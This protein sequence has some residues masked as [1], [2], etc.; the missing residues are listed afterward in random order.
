MKRAKI[1]FVFTLLF[2]CMAVTWVL[3]GAKNLSE[4]PA[5]T[6]NGVIDLAG[7]DLVN[8]IALLPLDW[9]YYPGHLYD[10]EQIARGEAGAPRV[11]IPE[12]E[13]AHQ[14]G[15]YR[16]VLQVAPG[17][18]YALAAWSIDYAT[19]IYIDGQE[20]LSIGIVSDSPDSFVPRTQSYVLPIFAQADT[21]EI[22][23]QYAN[24][25]H[26]EG[27]V[28]RELR[29]S[30]YEN[31][32]QYHRQSTIPAYLTSGSLLL[33]AVFYTLQFLL[34]RHA[35]VITFALCCLALALRSQTFLLSVLPIDYNWYFAYKFSFVGSVTMAVSCTLLLGFLYPGRVSR[36][37]VILYLCIA[38]AFVLAAVISPVRVV[39]RL[40]T[41]ATAVFAVVTVYLIIQ[42]IRLFFSK[43]PQDK[44]AAAGILAL[45]V[46]L[47]LDVTLMRVLPGITRNGIA[48]LGML[49]FV[50]CYML[51]LGIRAEE[52]AVHLRQERQRTENLAQLN[53]MKTEFL[54]NVTHELKTPLT[55]MS[56]SA[57]DTLAILPEGIP[58]R[59]GIIYNQEHIITEAERLDRIVIQLLDTAAIEAG[60]VTITREPISLTSLLQYMADTYFPRLGDNGNR[61][62]TDFAD[63]LPD[64]PADR[65]RIE[66]VVLN[67]LTNADRHTQNGLIT[68]TLKKDRSGQRVTVGDTG[69]GM[70]SDLQT[71]VFESYVSRTGGRSGMGLYICHKIIAAH[72]G[73][74]WIES[75]T[76]AGTAVSF[77]LPAH[78]ERD[79]A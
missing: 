68:L 52:N 45:F 6:E 54:Q 60:R 35:E 69:E 23:I 42:A 65:E 43:M 73:K 9:D 33:L 5:S 18:T 78:G 57:Q 39:A 67:L 49:V 27:G 47:F 51:L 17:K 24:L 15:T 11:F 16:A 4:Q 66:Q 59:T 41:P 75:G 53:A 56:S 28:F 25:H 2:S 1:I 62:D 21:V 22:V 3:S 64:I 48:A 58:D 30:T 38:A 44:L 31:I 34:Y 46:T 70:A 40:G 71:Q 10:P 36:R 79:E 8:A 19:R 29:F 61:L 14:T 77:W 12:D 74:I 76:E 26:P 13:R 20:A 7:M 37:A 72:G 55:V 63:S 32:Q 50:L